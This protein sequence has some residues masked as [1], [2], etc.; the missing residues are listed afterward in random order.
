MKI[1]LPRGWPEGTSGVAAALC[2]I[3]GATLAD[4]LVGVPMR[5][6][7]AGRVGVAQAQRRPFEARLCS[8]A[9][10]GAAGPPFE[11]AVAIGVE[12][13]GR[14]AGLALHRLVAERIAAPAAR[15]ERVVVGRRGQTQAIAGAYSG[16]QQKFAGATV[17]FSTITGAPR[18][19]ASGGKSLTNPSSASSESIVRPNNRN[20]IVRGR[21]V[22]LGFI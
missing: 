9:A 10:G 22:L 5:A 1:D 17:K 11:L 19:V 14:H 20:R 2:D 8:G 7:I 6:V 12:A 21:I 3:V 18:A 16:F 13:V 4:Q 15:H